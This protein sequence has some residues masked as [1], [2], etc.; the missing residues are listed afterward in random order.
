[1]S[2]SPDIDAVVAEV[3]KS[4]K[5][6]IVRMGDDPDLRLQLVPTGIEPLDEVLGGGI[7]RGRYCLVVGNFSTG[8]TYFCQR[9]IRAAQDR[10]LTTAFVDIERTFNPDWFAT[11]G[12]DLKRMPV[13]TPTTGEEAFDVLH[14]LVEA[15]ID[16]VVVDSLASMVPAAEADEG[17]DK[18]SV[19][20]QARL[21]NH[22]LRKL[23]TVNKN[24]AVLLT[25]QVRESIGGFHL[26][27]PESHPGGKGQDFWA[28]LIF[29]TRR[30]GWIMEGEGKNQRR[31]GFNMIFEI[32]KSKQCQPYQAVEV[33]FRFTGRLDVLQTIV[34]IAIERGVI[35]QRG[36]F[37]TYEGD[38]FQGR[39][40]LIDHLAALEGAEQALW[41]AAK[42]ATGQREAE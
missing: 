38:K 17:M 5:S 26:G 2:D 42:N 30:R 33:P 23:F 11:T 35:T 14:K 20:A 39:Q 15:G 34:D 16:L 6:T 25:N 9:V 28:W 32:T 8:K 3:N 13:A 4:L 18:V 1:M 37:Y 21:I 27:S 19:G 36:A 22:G 31:V 24:S 41:E 40:K 29:K 12:I 7:P 10:G